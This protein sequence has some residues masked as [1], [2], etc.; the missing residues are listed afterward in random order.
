[1][2]SNPDH[3]KFYDQMWGDLEW[4]GVIKVGP[5]NRMR[6]EIL[7]ARVSSSVSEGYRVCDFGCGDGS[8][9]RR[10]SEKLQCR[11]NLMGVDI[12]E[13]LREGVPFPF[14][15]ADLSEPGFCLNERVDLAVCSEVLEHVPDAVQVL[16][17]IH[18]SLKEGGLLHLSVPS[19]PIFSYDHRLG[20]L[21]HYSPTLLEKQLAEAGF[22]DVR[23]ERFGFPFHTAYKFVADLFP[24][25]QQNN[26]LKVHGAN[27]VARL[28]LDF[29][30]FLMMMSRIPFGGLQIFASARRAG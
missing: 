21:R 14:F 25:K 7:A 1:M 30:Y 24:V 16:K 11:V 2:Q 20:H 4:H 28:G 22:I 19:G 8:L 13:I 17:N 27:P 26:L 10:I 29:I 9:L 18:A 5:A 15:A 3:K 6:H 23:V 12:A